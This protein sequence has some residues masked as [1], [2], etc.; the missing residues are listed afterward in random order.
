M[1]IQTVP[2]VVAE[3]GATLTRLAESLEHSADGIRVTNALRAD[4][5]RRLAGRVRVQADRLADVHTRLL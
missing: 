3:V 1:S 2:E 5:V 4:E